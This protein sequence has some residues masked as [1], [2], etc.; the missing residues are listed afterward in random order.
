MKNAS[1]YWYQDDR[2]KEIEKGNPYAIAVEEEQKISN[3]REK[4]YHKYGKETPEE[5]LGGAFAILLTMAVLGPEADVG[6]SVEAEA[7]LSTLGEA[8]AGIVAGET[9]AAL[10]SVVDA[11]SILIATEEDIAALRAVEEAKNALLSNELEKASVSIKEAKDIL[12]NTVKVN[13][14]F[15]IALAAIQKTETK[16]DA[17]EKIDEQIGIAEKEKI[18]RF[19][20]MVSQN[21]YKDA[22]NEDLNT[23]YDF[24]NQY[25]DSV[26]SGVIVPV[27]GGDLVFR[28]GCGCKTEISPTM[29]INEKLN[30]IRSEVAKVDSLKKVIERIGKH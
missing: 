2:K 20:S 23:A 14:S 4:L 10:F 8:E 1:I 3:E 28:S 22:L 19:E 16:L 17:L 5:K 21:G 11:R 9:E 25:R 26:A 24:S 30:V 15:A 7:A 18:D 12:S 13:P 29:T 27:L 6:L